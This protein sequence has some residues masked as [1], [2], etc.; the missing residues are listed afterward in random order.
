MNIR[1]RKSNHRS[2]VSLHKPL[3]ENFKPLSYFVE[4]LGNKKKSIVINALMNLDNI[5]SHQDRTDEMFNQE[6]EVASDLM[7]ALAALFTADKLDHYGKVSKVIGLLS[8]VNGPNHELYKIAKGPLSSIIND[9]ENHVKENLLAHAID[10]LAFCC[11]ICCTDIGSMEHTIE[12]I[13]DLLLTQKRKLILDRA[14]EGWTLLLTRLDNSKILHYRSVLDRLTDFT[15]SSSQSLR[16]SACVA[17]GFIVDEIKDNISLEGS[18][19]DGNSHSAEDDY[20]EEDGDDFEYDSESYSHDEDL[21]E[22]TN[23]SKDQEYGSAS[24]RLENL[25]INEDNGIEGDGDLDSEE[26]EFE[27]EDEYEFN[28]DDDHMIQVIEETLQMNNEKGKK[29]IQSKS[30]LRQ[31]ISNLKDGEPPRETVIIRR[32]PFHFTGWRK[33]VQLQVMRRVLGS[34]MLYHWKNNTVLQDLFDVVLPE[35]LHIKQM[36]AHHKKIMSPTSNESKKKT[37]KLNRNRDAA[38]YHLNAGQ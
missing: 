23:F 9:G 34:G 16:M 38:Q 4:L 11:F 14:L 15:K 8:I 19:T 24:H 3:H 17:I 22:E 32:Y 29:K 25:H 18:T 13:Q 10:A 36:N 26:E 37:I 2:A 21:E 6:P 20:Y 12:S 30:L 1:T 7:K 27:D 28:I 35:N 5:L 33:Y 31:I